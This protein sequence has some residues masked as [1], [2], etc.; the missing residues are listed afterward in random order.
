M[1][2]KRLTERI[3]D[4]VRYDS[5]NYIV[6]CY[7]KNNNLSPIDKLVVKLCEFEDKKESGSL[8]ELPCKIGAV[9]WACLNGDIL[10]AKVWGISTEKYLYE[11]QIYFKV[12]VKDKRSYVFDKTLLLGK[13]V[14]LTK[15]EA[16]KAL[17]ERSATSED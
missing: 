17:K 12:R 5:G 16:E 2:S 10:K 3:G 15:E 4:G 13:S 7:P 1:K 11:E 8:L 14:F 9:V 6:T